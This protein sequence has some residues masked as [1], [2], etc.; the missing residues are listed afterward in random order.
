MAPSVSAAA[1]TG[2]RTSGVIVH[3]SE[4]S[5]G[6][7]SCTRAHDVITSNKH[8]QTHAHAHDALQRRVSRPCAQCRR[9]SVARRAVSIR[10]S[11][12]VRRRWCHHCQRC[13][14]RARSDCSASSAPA[15]VCC[16][17]AITA[18]Q[19]HLCSDSTT[20]ARTRLVAC[21]PRR[22]P[23]ATACRRVVDDV[24][25]AVAGRYD[26]AR[27]RHRD[28]VTEARLA[29][30]VVEISGNSLSG[31]GS[32]CTTHAR[33]TIVLA[34]I[35][36]VTLHTQLTRCCLTDAIVHVRHRHKIRAE[37]ATLRHANTLIQPQFGPECQRKSQID[38]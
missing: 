28:R 7:T 26:D 27:C 2:R 10:R 32:H 4:T 30:L 31:V 21:A 15:T 9:P 18:Q 16:V 38:C 13:L 8:A 33:V 3:R 36:R 19:T 14:T 23:A 1:C 25:A 11:Q 12:T 17:I 34:Q 29:R 37:L 6:C 22:R 20:G 24:R 35:T 5:I